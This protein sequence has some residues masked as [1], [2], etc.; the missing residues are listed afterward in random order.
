MITELILDG[1]F[2]LAGWFCGLLPPI[3]WTIETGAWE[4]GR[5]ALSM[6]C[7]LLPMDTIRGI[8]GCIIGLGIFR[9]MVAFVRFVLDLVPFV[10]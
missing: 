1:F 8:V 3:E 2:G 5:D 6:I 4:F 9:I 10:G 7:W